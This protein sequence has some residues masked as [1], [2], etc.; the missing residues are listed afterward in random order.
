MGSDALGLLNAWDIRQSTGPHPHPA[1]CAHLICLP[2]KHLC[3]SAQRNCTRGICQKHPFRDYLFLDDPNVGWVLGGWGGV[4]THRKLEA[5]I[6]NFLLYYLLFIY[7][8]STKVAV[9]D[10]SMCQPVF[11]FVSLWVFSWSYRALYMN[12]EGM[13]TR[14]VVTNTEL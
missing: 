7:T 8:T 5:D 12:C 11:F 13:E 3:S 10:I 4:H 2:E 14:Y 6:F 1:L 9:N